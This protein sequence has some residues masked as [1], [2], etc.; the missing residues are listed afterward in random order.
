MACTLPSKTRHRQGLLARLV[1]PCVSVPH[2]LVLR[3][4][5]HPTNKQMRCPCAPFCTAV[6]L[7][8]ADAVPLRALLH[9]CTPQT[10]ICSAPAR[11]S[12]QLHPSNK[13]MRCPCIPFCTAAPLKP[14]DAV[15]LHPL[16]HSCT[17]QTRRCSSPCISHSLLSITNKDLFHI[18]HT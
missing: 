18:P 16:L 2:T 11:P 13:Q 10:N 3:C 5:P 7:K 1:E 6:P 9:S 15:P 17:P 14:A 4:T 8:Q 12:A